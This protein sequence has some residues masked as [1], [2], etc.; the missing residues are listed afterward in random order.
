MEELAVNIKLLRNVPL[1]SSLNDKQL[2]SIVKAPENGIE[3]Y[4]HRE[5]VVRESEIADCMYIV[6]CGTLEI[7]VR[8]I[9][10]V[11]EI[12]I[13]T[14]RPGDFF[15]EQA[16]LPGSTGR[17]NANVRAM[18][19]TSVFRIDKKYVELANGQSS[20]TATFS[21]PK[22]KNPAV[23]KI[24]LNNV[25]D[26]LLSIPFFK[27]LNQSEITHIKDWTEIVS[28]GAREMIIKKFAKGEYLYVVLN[29]S[30]EVFN[31]DD[32]GQF[33]VLAELSIG[34]I[35]GEQSLLPEG[36]G[37]SNAFV[38]TIEDSRMLRIAKRHFRV[39]VAR[40]K[41]IVDKIKKIQLHTLKN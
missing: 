41:D 19:I 6:L 39:I 37:I 36:T 35:F 33:I 27:N 25:A 5:Q 31:V 15:G 1:F 11:R 14:L 30:V 28:F 16:L 17:R 26:F 12:A 38:R 18:K 34:R 29:G 3:T 23:K 22:S 10:P 24:S 4:K 7:T 13:A 9:P 2:Y 21:S 32:Q 40:N 20:E 8:G